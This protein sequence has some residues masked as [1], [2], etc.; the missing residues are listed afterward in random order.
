MMETKAEHMSKGKIIVVDDTTA[1]LTLLTRTLVMD[2]FDVRPADSGALALAS[3]EQDVPDLVL[4][5]IRMPEMDGFEVCRRLRLDERTHNVPII[6]LSAAG[7]LEDRIAGLSMGAVDYLTKPFY[8]EELLARVRTHVELARLRADLE[9]AVAERTSDL[10]DANEKLRQNAEF[11]RRFLR[12]VLA[13]VS[14]GVLTLCHEMDDIPAPLSTPVGDPIVLT[15]GDSLR[16]LRD[17]TA[18]AADKVQLDDARVLDIVTAAHEAGMN[19]IVHVGAG[20]AQVTI[21][22]AAGKVQIRV[23]DTG[24]GISLEQLP[25]AAFQKG[26]T[27]SGTLGYGMKIMLGM[28]DSVFLLTG[29]TGTTVVLEQSCSGGVDDMGATL[30]FRLA[31][32]DMGVDHTLLS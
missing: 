13:S 8:R 18:E 30:A 24:A 5:D 19:S 25:R 3:A 31:H 20:V 14:N 4:L 12:D 10:T 22:E 21:D 17:R 7:E 6:F 32:S 2:G 16:E 9:A 26:Y 1:S 11:Q 15:F 29:S 27:T 28:V 23:E